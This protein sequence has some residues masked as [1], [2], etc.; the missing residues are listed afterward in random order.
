MSPRLLGCLSVRMLHHAV[1]PNCGR[2]AFVGR[3]VMTAVALVV[4]DIVVVLWLAVRYQPG[5]FPVGVEATLV[6]VACCSAACLLGCISEFAVTSRA[7]FPRWLMSMPI[8]AR[9]VAI[10]LRVP[11]AA[12]LFM[13]G[14]FALGPASLLLS[15]S[16]GVDAIHGVVATAIVMVTGASLAPSFV[17]IAQALAIRL[18]RGSFYGGLV[19]AVWLA[20]AA[21]SGVAMRTAFVDGADHGL[22][23]WTNL[24]GWPSV[25]RA[26]LVP[27]AWVMATAL[28]T[29]SM[30]IVVGGIA[31]GRLRAGTEDVRT[32]RIRHG[33]HFGYMPLLVLSLTRGVRN[34]RSRAHLSAALVFVSVAAGIAIWRGERSTLE[35][36]VILEA[37]FCAMFAL[38]RRS[39]DGE[40]PV[41]VRLGIRPSSYARGAVASSTIVGLSLIGL[42]TVAA[43]VFIDSLAPVATGTSVV[44]LACVL[45]AFFGAVF[46]PEPGDSSAELLVALVTLGSLVAVD[47][48]AAAGAPGAAGAIGMRMIVVGLL[49]LA[50]PFV[51]E[52]RWWRTVTPATMRGGRL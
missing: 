24:L 41:E 25:V 38:A 42:T 51:E 46:A 12:A 50:V 32:D 5:M 9:A 28:G 35:G 1:L 8:S 19:I 43:G 36:A 23:L 39:L 14:C 37:L 7:S 21:A 48:L 26:V 4:A 31:T 47:N 27:D 10:I 40:I 16:T 2:R 11:S 52:H 45:G 22:A 34:P 15:R 44:F 30:I 33:R 3:V 49:A 20:W 6:M 18:R 29:S 17:L 13:A